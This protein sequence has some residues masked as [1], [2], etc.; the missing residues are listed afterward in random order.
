MK[1]LGAF[2]FWIPVVIVAALIYG[3]LWRVSVATI[4][5]GNNG[6][7]GGVAA[8]VAVPCMIIGGFMWLFGDDK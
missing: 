1:R 2:L 6:G 7:W 4:M 5:A 8:L 3:Q